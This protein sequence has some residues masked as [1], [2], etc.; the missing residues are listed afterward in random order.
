MSSLR[1]FFQARVVRINFSDESPHPEIMEFI[2]DYPLRSCIRFSGYFSSRITS[3]D[4]TFQRK[5]LSEGVLIIGS[6]GDSIPLIEKERLGRVRKGSMSH[7]N[8]C[9]HLPESKYLVALQSISLALASGLNQINIELGTSGL[10]TD[11]TDEFQTSIISLDFSAS[12]E[13]FP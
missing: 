5:D 3:A 8:A 1:L 4:K 10:K 2:Q 6:T 12:S 9:A 11:S 13:N 7:V